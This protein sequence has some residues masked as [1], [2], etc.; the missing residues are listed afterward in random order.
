MTKKRTAKEWS[1]VVERW[2]RSG[3]SAKEFATA[4]GLRASTLSWWKWHLGAKRTLKKNP[5]QTRA[6]KKSASKKRVQHAAKAGKSAEPIRLVELVVP[7]AVV[8]SDAPIE[9]V[10]GDDVVIRVRRGFDAETLRRLLV[11]F[12]SDAARC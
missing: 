12:E 3:L 5:S 7:D 8:T 9:L 2:Q 1:K 11:V 6:S 4:E 10:L